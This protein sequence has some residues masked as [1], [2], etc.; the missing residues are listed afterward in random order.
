[1][2][3]VCFLFL[4]GATLSCLAQN[5]QDAPP[6]N[7]TQFPSGDAAWTIDITQ[8]NPGGATPAATGRMQKV[9]IAL[10]GDI[11]RIIITWVDGKTTERWHYNS[12]KVTFDTNTTTGDPVGIKDWNLAFTPKTG[13]EA[14]AFSFAF[15]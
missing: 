8:K 12:L 4:L 2:N 9:D 11:Q 1:M 14:V 15:Q 10:L 3:K 7:P 5:A 13:F 6:G